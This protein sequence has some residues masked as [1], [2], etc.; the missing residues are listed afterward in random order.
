MEQV[1]GLRNEENYSS[2]HNIYGVQV[3]VSIWHTRYHILLLPIHSHAA[4]S[5]L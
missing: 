5:I 1:V 4:N 3:D 2:L